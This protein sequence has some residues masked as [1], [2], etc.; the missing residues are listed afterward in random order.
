MALA[1][2]HPD[3]FFAVPRLWEKLQVAIEAMVDGLPPDARDA[4]KAA[5]AAGDAYEQVKPILSRLGLERIKA[6]DVGGAPN[7]PELSEFFRAVGVPLLEAYGLTEGALNIFNRIEEFKGGTAGKPL[8]G[9]EFR[10]ADDGEILLRGGLNFTGYRKQAR[11]VGRRRS[12][13]TAG[14]TPATSPRSTRTGSSRSSTA[15]RRSSSA[16]PA[17]TCRRPTSSRRS[18]A[19]AR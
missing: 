10:L 4:A 12:T 13:P 1:E 15:R 14:S 17:R 2:R 8:P 19:R 9:V 3:V 6:A 5:I 7:A 18:R 16:P 11:R